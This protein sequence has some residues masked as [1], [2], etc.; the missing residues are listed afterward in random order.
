MIARMNFQITADHVDELKNLIKQAGAEILKYFHSDVV[1]RV[2][3]DESPV[4]DADKASEDIIVSG[5]KAIAPNIPIIAEELT[6]AGY[7]P[8]IENSDYFWLVDPLDGTKEFI[9][10]TPDFVINI[11]LVHHDVPVF[12]MVYVPIS[13]DL[14]YGGKNIGAFLND[15]PINTKKYD[16][17]VG[18]TMIG[19]EGQKSLPLMQ[20][21]LG[22]NKIESF[23]MRGSSIKFCMVADG[24]AHFYPRFIP[25]YEWDTAAAHA[26]LLEIGGDIID[27]ETGKRLSYRKNNYLNSWLLT[28]T[29]EV[30]S[31]FSNLKITS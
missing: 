7:A 23:V 31:L 1:I 14:Y 11:S 30:L 16:V 4:T 26:I 12:G 21:S 22:E 5:L 18:L 17:N 10:G 25:T 24:T 6:E 3:L 29:T 27:F 15:R 28:T 2:K 8:D 13:G 20:K 9:K 19:Q